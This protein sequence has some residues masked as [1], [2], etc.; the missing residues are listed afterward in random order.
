MP[1]I[2]PQIERSR[3]FSRVSILLLLLVGGG[4]NVS[5]ANPDPNAPLGPDD[6]GRPVGDGGAGSSSAMAWSSSSQELYSQGGLNLVAIDVVAG[7][8]RVVEEPSRF[9]NYYGFG[10]I[11]ASPDGAQLY[12][13]LNAPHAATLYVRQLAGG[14][15]VQI[16][17]ASIIGGS[18]T[19][20]SKQLLYLGDNDSLFAY[21]AATGRARFVRS[22]CRAIQAT[23]PDSREVL[24]RAANPP[25]TFERV[26]IADGTASS[27]VELPA[28]EEIVLVRWNSDGI[29]VLHRRGLEYYVSNVQ[30]GATAR[31]LADSGGIVSGYGSQ[32]DWSRD[33]K[34]LALWRWHCLR[35]TGLL[36]CD[37]QEGLTLL[38]V[39]TF[40]AKQVATV[41]VRSGTTVSAPLLSPDGRRVA[42][43]AAGTIYVKDVP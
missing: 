34:T 26:S 40:A 2:K 27:V 5:F 29:R 25:G 31:V 19:P 41:N 13:S 15:T 9:I 32:F 12:Y 21:T 33:G 38:D 30:T 23:S 39:T 11:I 14:Q 8:P 37:I 22:G 17:A 35:S 28:L 42:Y 7:T 4:C 20:D 16:G 18:V 36:S 3:A 6:R 24:C 1:S 10:Q 43:K